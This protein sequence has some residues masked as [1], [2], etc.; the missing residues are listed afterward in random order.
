MD[1]HSSAL[2]CSRAAALAALLLGVPSHALQ[3]HVSARGVISPLG[4][5][6]ASTLAVT[7]T[8]V[9]V[10][11]SVASRP[12]TEESKLKISL[13]NKGRT[14][15]NAGKKHSEETKSRIAEATRRAAVGSWSQVGV[16]RPGVFDAADD[17][18]MGR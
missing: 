16:G 3:V 17:A 18:T 10:E 1:R 13:A 14:P 11:A 5:R 4:R 6:R 9:Q 8:A 2:R 15:W 7:S 12:H